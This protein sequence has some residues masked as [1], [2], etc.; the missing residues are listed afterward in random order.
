MCIRDRTWTAPGDDGQ[1]GTAARYELRYAV[2]PIDETSW[3]Q[4]FIAWNLP[5]PS[6]PGT[7]EHL[8]LS[9]L[10]TG[11]LYYIA[12]KTRDEARNLSDISNVASAIATY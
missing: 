5:D 11:R 1:T 12:I 9:S 7:T 8:T 3:D 4:V 6:P 2:E 10:S